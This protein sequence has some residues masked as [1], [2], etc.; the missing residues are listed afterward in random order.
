[1]SVIKKL[2]FYFRVVKEERLLHLNELEELINE[3]YDNARIYKDKTNKWNDQRILRRE[4][5]AGDQVLLFN[6]R[7]KLFPGKPK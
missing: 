6:S 1:M 7:L 3:A 4:F 5:K 2:N